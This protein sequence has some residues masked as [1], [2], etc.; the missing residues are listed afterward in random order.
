MKIFKWKFL[1]CNGIWE[2]IELITNKHAYGQ[3]YS[4]WTVLRNRIFMN[5]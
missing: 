2:L 5:H 4:F 3:Y 1:A